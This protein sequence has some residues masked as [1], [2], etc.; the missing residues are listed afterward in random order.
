MKYLCIQKQ[1]KWDPRL[2]HF[3]RRAWEEKAAKRYADMLFKARKKLK[4]ALDFKPTSID[5]ET[6]ARWKNDWEHRE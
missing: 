3:V 5:S 2:D 6:W 1:Y 4:S